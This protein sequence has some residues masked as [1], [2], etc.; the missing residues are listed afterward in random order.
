[1]I[2]LPDPAY[3]QSHYSRDK[4]DSMDKPPDFASGSV[5]CSVADKRRL[6]TP[7]SGHK[8]QLGAE[9]GGRP[10]RD[11]KRHK[12]T[13]TNRRVACPGAG[14]QS[15]VK[16]PQRR[17]KPPEFGSPDTKRKG[18]REPIPAPPASRDRRPT[19]ARSATFWGGWG[20]WDDRLRCGWTQLVSRFMITVMVEQ[21]KLTGDLITHFPD[22]GGE[23]VLQTKGVIGNEGRFEAF[24][25]YQILPNFTIFDQKRAANGLKHAKKRGFL[26]TDLFKPCQV[27]AARSS[28][29]LEVISH[30]ESVFS[31][32]RPA[33]LQLEN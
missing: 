25:G 15:K 19:G 8:P 5:I 16:P 24:F 11:G 3:E 18:G 33:E 31:S 2:Q 4:M 13:A 20:A 17:W 12:R 10:C 28:L 27:R 6:I 7:N 1:M 26:A 9:L 14:G 29:K 23:P 32:H 22:P 30:Q 21:R